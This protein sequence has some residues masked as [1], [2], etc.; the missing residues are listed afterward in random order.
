M[1]AP[2][3]PS[4]TAPQINTAVGLSELEYWGSGFGSSATTKLQVNF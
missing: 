4:S 1:K 3:P 2:M